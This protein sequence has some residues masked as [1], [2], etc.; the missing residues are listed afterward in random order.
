MGK[1]SLKSNA[2]LN[3]VKTVVGLI[4]PLITFPY[5]SRI[6][7]V[8]SI[9]VYN[10]SSSII[11]Y[12]LLIAGLG[13]AVYG[14]REGS[15]YREDKEKISRFVSEVFTINMWSTIF[16]Y[17][18]L[19]ITVFC[20]SKLHDYS[21]AIGILSLEIFFTTIGVS[22]VCN[23]FEDF[24]FITI[25]S[26]SVQ[27][28]SLLLTLIFVKNPNDIY[29]YIA[30]VAFSKIISG[31]VSFLYVQ[32]KC[33]RFKWVI[34]C[35][36]K[37]HIKPIM[38]IFSTSIAMTV[39]VSSDMTMLGF[40]TNDYQVGLYSTA[41]KIYT[42]VK[43]VLAAA[44]V[45]LVPRFSIFF[46]NKDEKAND[47]FTNAFNSMVVIV[48]PAVVGLALTSK[49]V[50][51]LIG[52]EKYLGGVESLQLLCLAIAFSLF[53]TLYTQCILIPLKKEKLVFIAT[54][55]SAIVNFSLN[56][57][58]IPWLGINGAAIT[59]IIAEILVCMIAVICSKNYI[60]LGKCS[61][62]FIS[63]TIGCVLF[64]LVG[65]C[66]KNSI[67]I[68]Y[69]RLPVTVAVSCIIYLIVLILT[70]NEFLYS[71]LNKMKRK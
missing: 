24:L 23:I 70:K 63:V 57:V 11:S 7:Q 50:V 52:G 49:D 25:Q 40:M 58:F 20:V 42:I 34:S 71:A 66:I 21:L 8:E 36:L 29:I 12:F 65:M 41:V 60:K 64:F 10:F 51:R 16:S 19:L 31:I 5:I 39:Y 2:I 61:K 1:M 43:N 62:N 56:L 15:R 32:A 47:L 4:F 69:I 30:I 3:T 33:C 46:E 53:A 68:Y 59:T 45:V 55:L 38:I 18:C 6:L 17:I 28:I 67:T 9:G 22:W 48:F 44:L 37:K 14:V 13:V 54:L 26:I 27:V 35:D